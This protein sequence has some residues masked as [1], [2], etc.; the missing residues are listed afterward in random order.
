[1]RY[2]AKA[3]NFGIIYG[4]GPH[5]L[6]QTADISYQDARDFIS[7]YFDVHSKIND[8]LED[9]KDLATE[10]GYV[11]TFF[12]R[13]RYLPEIN[14]NIQQV[15]AGAERAAINHPIQGT[16]ADLMKL[17]MIEIDKGL[18]EISE[19]TKMI[20]QVHDELVFEVPDQDLK[21][22]AKF[23]E[24]KMEEV[25]KLKTPVETHIEVGNNWG[26]LNPIQ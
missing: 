10:K 24:T 14:S 13:R 5:G 22:V 19:K 4:Q 1:M 9:V 6:A 17:A 20:L 21:K 12:G 8:Y 11:E 16:A 3:I 7:R 23:V 18:P 25:Y 26:S 15:R 2:A